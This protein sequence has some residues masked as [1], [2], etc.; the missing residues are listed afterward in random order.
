MGG[1]PNVEVPPAGAAFTGMMEHGVSAILNVND[2]ASA[3]KLSGDRFGFPKQD[4]RS[5][6]YWLQTV[7][8][9]PLLDHRT[10]SELPSSADIVIVGSGVDAS[11]HRQRISSNC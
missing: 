9:D 10:T 1:S 8:N 7:R 2:E 5:L 3:P 6:S 4:G 11:I